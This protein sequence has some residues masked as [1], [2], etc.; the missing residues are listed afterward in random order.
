MVVRLCKDNALLGFKFVYGGNVDHIKETACN[1]KE[2]NKAGAEGA[3]Q[4]RQVV[5]E[6]DR[7]EGGKG[8]F[9]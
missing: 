5:N 6:V 4:V 9:I 1:E 7:V 3:G 8:G 2:R